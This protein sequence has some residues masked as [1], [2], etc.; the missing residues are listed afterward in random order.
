MPP[1]R[2]HQRFA[3]E[4]VEGLGERQLALQRRRHH[5]RI[6]GVH[7]EGDAQ[8]G[9]FSKIGFETDARVARW[10]YAKA[11][12][13][14]DQQS[15]HIAIRCGPDAMSDAGCPEHFHRLANDIRTANLSCMRHEAKPGG[16]RAVNEAGQ[17][18]CGDRLVAH[19]AD[20]DHPFS[21]EGDVKRSFVA[22]GG[23]APDKLN[24]PG[25]FDAELPRNGLAA[26][27]D[28]LDPTIARVQARSE[29]DLVVG[30]VLARHYLALL[31]Y[32]PLENLARY[33]ADGDHPR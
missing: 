8:V 31:R 10:A 2:G 27:D 22:F 4:S 11:H 16:A 15:Q 9:E 33:N 19:Q 5:G 23:P 13:A 6:V 18:R 21:G 7:R 20:A 24:Q 30:D 25:D 1:S 26:A 29:T 14:I 32:D 28:A 12:T 3:I 17:G